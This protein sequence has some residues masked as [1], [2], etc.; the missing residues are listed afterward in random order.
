MGL[1]EKEKEPPKMG[2]SKKI[3]EPIKKKEVKKS[4]QH[5]L[6]REKSVFSATGKVDEAEKCGEKEEE[7][8]KKG[9]PGW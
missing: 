3:V 9:V 8:A 2:Y 1:V 6:S 4:R 7:G 5:I